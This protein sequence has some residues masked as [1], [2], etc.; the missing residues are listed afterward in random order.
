MIVGSIPTAPTIKIEVIQMPFIYKITNKIN[1]KCYIGKTMS[2]IQERW[3]EH[4]NDYQKERHQN[5]P[6]YR[7]MRKYGV[8]SFEISEIE[9]CSDTLLSEREKYWISYYDTYR[10][11]YNATIGGDGTQ[12]VDYDLVVHIYKLT[13]NQ[14]ETA[15][16]VGIDIATVKSILNIRNV[17]LISR[18]QVINE[19]CGKNVSMFSLNGEYIE[20]FSSETDAAKYVL[21]TDDVKLISGA[22]AHISSVCKG[23]RKTAYRYKWS[24]I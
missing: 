19:T 5:R 14:K 16:I 9:N 2:T 20:T 21:Q 4:C 1:G 7:A 13:H 12:Y 3:K 23:K 24:Y 8:D 18:N 15:R 11:G 17:E 10:N 22:A 6:L